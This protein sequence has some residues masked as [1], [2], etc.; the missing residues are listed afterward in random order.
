MKEEKPVKVKEEK[1]EKNELSCNKNEVFKIV[2]DDDINYYCHNNQD[3][4]I[5]KN[6]R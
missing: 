3:F 5:L 6:L 1:L 4:F 2:E